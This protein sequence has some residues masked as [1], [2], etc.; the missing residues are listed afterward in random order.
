MAAPQGG[1]KQALL[2]WLRF[3]P[4][5][6]F[7]LKKEHFDISLILLESLDDSDMQPRKYDYD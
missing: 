2:A 5:P 3:L 6:L 4:P 1:T 7:L